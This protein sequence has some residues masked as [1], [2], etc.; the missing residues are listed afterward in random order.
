[1]IDAINK[2]LQ[3]KEKEKEKIA[4]KSLLFEEL[5]ISS[6]KDGYIDASQMCKVRNKFFADWIRLESTK[7]LIK[8]LEESLMAENSD[9]EPISLLDIKKGGTNQ[10]SWIHPDLAVNLAIWIDKKFAIHVSRFVRELAISG[11]C[12]SEK[13]TSNELLQL[14]QEYDKLKITHRKLLEKKQHHK[15]KKGPVFYI[16][17][18]TDSKNTKYK[19]GIETVDINIRLAQH[20]STTPCIKLEFLIYTKD[21]S[22]IEKTVLKRYETKRYHLNHEWIYDVEIDHIIKSVKTQ[23]DFMSI[24]HTIEENLSEYNLHIS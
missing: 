21:C 9:M 4:T 20:R 11:H 1:M 10:G 8:E 18:D 6:R 17:S 13:K 14:Q 15:F 23:L 22:L 2:T 7:E 5:G 16:I 12:T 24:D 19:P 3:Q